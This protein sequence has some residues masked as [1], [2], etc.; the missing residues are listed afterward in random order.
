MRPALNL[1]LFFSYCL[2]LF[3]NP[4]KGFF[5][6]FLCVYTCSGMNTQWGHFM[7]VEIVI[8]DAILFRY[9]L[10]PFHIQKN[11][12]GISNFFPLKRKKGN[13]SFSFF[14]NIRKKEIRPL[15]RLCWVIVIQS[16]PFSLCLGYLKIFCVFRLILKWHCDLYWPIRLS[17]KLGKYWCCMLKGSS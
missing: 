17:G 4:E 10:M 7:S 12:N 8:I 6:L 1:N 3:V 9:I 15:K 2:L 13:K 11:I 14:D 16:W 5:L